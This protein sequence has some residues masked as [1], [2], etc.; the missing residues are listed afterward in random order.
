MHLHRLIIFCS[1]P[2]TLAAFYVRA[3]AMEVLSRDGSFV[4]V[5]HP[6][7]AST[8]IGFHKGKKDKNGALKP[9]FH[10]TDIAADRQRLVAL[11]ASMGKVVGAPDALC[12]C[13]GKDPEG[14]LLQISNRP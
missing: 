14:N 10:S 13:D 9:C 12:F 4:D 8:R 2:E 5:G 1:D 6:G 11:G 3:F 7:S